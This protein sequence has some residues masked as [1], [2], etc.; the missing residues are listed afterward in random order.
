MIG[1]PWDEG[2]SGEGAVNSVN[3]LDGDVTLT[4]GDVGADPVGAGALAG[5]W[6]TSASASSCA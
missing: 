1:T 4:A 6:T 5:S 3:G 2:S